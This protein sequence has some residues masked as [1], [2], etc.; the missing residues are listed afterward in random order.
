MKG[1]FIVCERLLCNQI[2][3]KIG[4]KFSFGETTGP[5]AS[6]SKMFHSGVSQLTL[7]HFETLDK[8]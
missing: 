8:K 2:K 5:Y 4:S 7:S 3:Q 1:P 6:I